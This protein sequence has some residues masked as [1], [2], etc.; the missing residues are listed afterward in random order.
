MHVEYRVRCEYSDCYLTEYVYTNNYSCFTKA[1]K[2]CNEYFLETLYYMFGSNELYTLC[3]R[4]DDEG[5]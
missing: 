2:K 4:L 1:E 3:P 5:D